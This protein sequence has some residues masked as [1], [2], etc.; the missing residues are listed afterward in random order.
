MI[1]VRIFQLPPAAVLDRV[2][3]AR[4]THKGWTPGLDIGAD[5]GRW[6]GDQRRD[7]AGDCI[8][9][10][11]HAAGTRWWCPDSGVVGKKEPNRPAEIYLAKAWIMHDPGVK[12][13]PV[14]PCRESA[15]PPLPHRDAAYLRTVQM[16][17]LKYSAVR[18]DRP[19]HPVRD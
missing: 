1:H 14:R 11:M 9:G 18:W 13:R 16:L 19:A 7:A 8:G 3:S 17:I 15:T 6:I 4:T 10:L 5:I 2:D 12:L